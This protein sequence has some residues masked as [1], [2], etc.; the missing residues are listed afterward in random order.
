MAKGGLKGAAK[1]R[2]MLRRVPQAVRDEMLVMMDQAGDDIL[3][4]QQADAPYRYGGLRGALSKRLLRG[5][6]RLRVGLVGKAVNRLRFYGR[7]LEAGRKAKT[8]QV[9]KGGLTSE[10]RAA[11]GRSNRYKALAKRMGAQ[12]YTMQVKALPARRFISSQRTREM[13]NTL[14]GRLNGFWSR[15]LQDVSGGGASD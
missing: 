7:I 11:G 9:V 14:G 5:S 15:V 1:V 6:L 8:V 10:V 12:S 2:S 13:R 4:A 3:A